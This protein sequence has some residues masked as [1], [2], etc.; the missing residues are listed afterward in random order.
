[1]NLRHSQG[2]NPI[3]CM[4]LWCT[5]RKKIVSSCEAILNATNHLY[6]CR[7]EWLGEESGRRS[8]HEDDFGVLWLYNGLILCVVAW[9]RELF[10][11]HKC[12]T[13]YVLLGFTYPNKLSIEK[14]Y[15]MYDIVWWLSLCLL[16]W[17]NGYDK[18]GCM[19]YFFQLTYSCVFCCD[20]LLSFVMIT[21][22]M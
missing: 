6:S 7:G 9:V 5:L 18:N 3:K 8:C 11:H 12:I 15:C 19:L 13:S 4:V 21:L 17:L 16:C 10:H 22:W 14:S 2:G 20:C 1:M